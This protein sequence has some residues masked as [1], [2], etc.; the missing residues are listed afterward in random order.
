MIEATTFP[1]VEAAVTA[2]LQPHLTGVIVSNKTPSP[3]P[4]KLVTVGYSGGGSRDWFEAGVNVGINVYAQSDDDE[5]GA[6]GCRSFARTVQDMLAAVSNDDIEH[7]QV[8]AGGGTSVP[9]QSPP[10]QRYFAAT[11]Y[12]RAQAV[13]DLS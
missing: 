8:G 12:L 7:I 11:V 9:R 2:A 3:I 1:D 10:F 4:A 6:T 5:P 13:L